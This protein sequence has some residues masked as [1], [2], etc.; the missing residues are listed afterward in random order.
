MTTDLD[1]IAMLEALEKTTTNMVY[2]GGREFGERLQPIIAALKTQNFD[3]TIVACSECYKPFLL[4][5]KRRC[6]CKS[7]AYVCIEDI[8]KDT[9]PRSSVEALR[10]EYHYEKSLGKNL[11]GINAVI[12]TLD[13]L[14]AGKGG[15][16]K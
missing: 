12:A 10:G 2:V 4:Q 11:I 7:D 8:T 16:E 5:Q 1:P 13:A 9:I 3:N 6:N 14:L 15:V